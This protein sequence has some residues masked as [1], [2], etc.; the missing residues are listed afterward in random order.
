[1]KIAY[2]T[3]LLIVAICTVAYVLN[4]PEHYKPYIPHVRLENGTRVAVLDG[5]TKELLDK[6]ELVLKEENI[7]FKRTA[8]SVLE[9][10]M[11]FYSNEDKILILENRAYNDQKQK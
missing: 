8:E 6:M 5:R 2:I 11:S 9:V 4:A 10:P 7:Q 1:M 3:I